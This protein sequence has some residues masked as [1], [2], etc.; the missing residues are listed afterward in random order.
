MCDSQ[1]VNSRVEI[2]PKDFHFP[3][4]DIE[5]G[6]T[7]KEIKRRMVTDRNGKRVWPNCVI[8]TLSKDN[9]I[10]FRL[11]LPRKIKKDPMSMVSG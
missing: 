1:N 5:L 11:F 10:L 6:G 8:A 2:S 4:D 7:L 9:T 3:D